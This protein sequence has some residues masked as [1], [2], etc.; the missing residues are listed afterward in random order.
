MDFEFDR[1]KAV[2][3]ISKH[4]VSFF[5]AVTAL[6]DRDALVLED[7]DALDENRWVLLGMSEN[8]KLLVVVY[9]LR[10]DTVRV[11]S[12]R[13]ATNREHRTYAQRI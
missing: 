5:E 10:V 7:T 13:M 11:I 12:A 1:D 6:Y 8:L 9:T 4:G 2:A 3:N